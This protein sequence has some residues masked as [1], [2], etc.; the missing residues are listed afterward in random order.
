MDGHAA[1]VAARESGGER[2]QSL[3]VIRI[4]RSTL[5]DVS[6]PLDMTKAAS[7]GVAN[8]IRRFRLRA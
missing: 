3:T 8:F 2:V 6:T 7:P 4:W 1:R 5:T